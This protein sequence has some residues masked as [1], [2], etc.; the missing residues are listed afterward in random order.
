MSVIFRDPPPPA[1]DRTLDMARLRLRLQRE[2]D[3]GYH[4]ERLHHIDLL[5]IDSDGVARL[6][7]P[8]WNAPDASELGDLLIA[9]GSAVKSDFHRVVEHL[10]V[11]KFMFYHGSRKLPANGPFFQ[12]MERGVR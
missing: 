9:M 1:K 3:V 4:G 10:A 12:R 5:R 8:S 2:L 6:V 11:Y 7:V